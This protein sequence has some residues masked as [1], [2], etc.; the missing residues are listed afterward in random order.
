VSHRRKSAL[1]TLIIAI[2]LILVAAACG[3]S[4]KSSEPKPGK[5]GEGDF[6]G[7]FRDYGTFV[8]GP[9]EH[10]DPGL[11]TTLDAFQ[12]TD[13]LYD[14]LT[15][16][17]STDINH[18][19]LKP[20]VAESWEPNADGTVWTFKIKKGLTFSDGSPVLPSSF[21][22][23]WNRASEPKFAGDYSYLMN[24]IKGGAERLAYKGSGTAPPLDIKADDSTMTLTTT[25]SKPYANWPTV[26]GFQLFMPM[27][28]AVDN[29]K[30]QNSW[31]NGMMIGNGPYKLEKPRTDTEI[32][33]VR[34]DK[35]GG[36]I[37]GNTKATLD[38]IEFHV[39]ADP[40]TAYAAFEAGEADNANIP[41]AKS[42]EADEKY[43]TTLDNHILGTYYYDFNWKDPSVGGE[44]NLELRRA[45]S[46]GINREQIN[47]AVYDG[48]RTE[49]HGVA[50]PGM[51]Y[52]KPDICQYC[53]YDLNAAKEH[54]QK[55]KDAG[56]TQTKPIKI[57]FNTGA[58]HEDVVSI[59]V[60]N[61]KQ[62][63]IQAEADGMDTETFF[64]KLGDGACIF[65]RDGWYADYPTYDNF[66][67]DLF[68]TDAIGGNNHGLY[69]N[70][71]FD[72]LVAEAKQ[73]KDDTTAADDYHKAEDILLNQDTA[74]V[75]INFYNGDYV[76][77]PDQVTKFVQT[78]MGIIL[79][80]Q[81]TVKH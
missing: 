2:A 52:Y 71:E 39:S 41:P 10:I 77:N 51:Q 73:T 42:K 45:I 54:L 6:G 17:D 20:L 67:Y 28:P 13:A 53:T 11:N 79:W 56:N 34:N 43:A 15:D 61:L 7:T 32:D 72:K 8:G 27:P 50:P 64:T 5:A 44:K 63:G 80:A 23:G 1:R 49:A 76:Y 26:A 75:P 31:E 74:V 55:W 46:M 57:Q 4:S 21:V 68:S 33:V 22:R 65:C 62:V 40:D 18:P 30:D 9:P 36:D 16:M 37:F 70:P 38:K 19:V 25:L 48:K 12:L 35:W 58:G 78:N 66:T 24:F 47:Q 60:D 3:S 69:S 81:V 14:G 59:I 29:L